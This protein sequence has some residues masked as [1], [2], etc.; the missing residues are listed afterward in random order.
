MIQRKSASLDMAELYA[1]VFTST[2]LGTLAFAAVSLLGESLLR[3]RFGMS[4]GGR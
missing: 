3:R 2:A 1:T 4:L